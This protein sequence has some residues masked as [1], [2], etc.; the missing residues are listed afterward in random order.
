[1][2]SYM[3]ETVRFESLDDDESHFMTTEEM[4]IEYLKTKKTV[5]YNG[6]RRAFR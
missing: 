4:A 6:V 2:N 3:A 1:M 5:S